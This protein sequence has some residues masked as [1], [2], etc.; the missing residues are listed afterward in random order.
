MEVLSVNNKIMT[1]NGKWAKAPSTTGTGDMKK[2]VYDPTGS[3]A[4]AGGIPDYVANNAPVVSVNGKTGDVTVREV[5]SV[6][7]SDNGKFLRVVSGAW[8]A[9]SISDAHGGSF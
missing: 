1:V 4:T 6:T 7:A 9:V 5:P 8:A 3:V 2:S